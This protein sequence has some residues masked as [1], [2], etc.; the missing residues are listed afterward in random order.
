MNHYTFNA[1]HKDGVTTLYDWCWNW[2]WGVLI[3]MDIIIHNKT[4]PQPSGLEG[5]ELR[6]VLGK[7]FL[8]IFLKIKMLHLRLY[9]GQY[10]VSQRS[11]DKVSHV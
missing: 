5:S 8:R 4:Q 9:W 11:D 1:S 3:V 2:F 7:F 10:N 6:G